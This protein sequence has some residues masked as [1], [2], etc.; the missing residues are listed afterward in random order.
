MPT[1]QPPKRRGRRAGTEYGTRGGGR[2]R[3]RRTLVIDGV[4]QEGH[5]LV[6]SLTKETIVLQSVR[7]EC[8][9]SE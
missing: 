7:T 1:P 2:P 8:G 4:L 5:Y 9:E 6:V 3:L